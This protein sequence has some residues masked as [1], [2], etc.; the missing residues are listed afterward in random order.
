MAAAECRYK[1]VDRQLKEQFIHGL[2]DNEMLSEVIRELTKGREDVTISS[3]TVLGGKRVEAQR[4]QTVVIS[5]LWESR[6]CDAIA[7]KDNKHRDKN[8][9]ATQTLPEEYAS[10]N[11][12]DAQNMVTCV[13]DVARSIIL[14]WYAEGPRPVQSTPLRK[15][16]FKSKNL[17]SKWS[18]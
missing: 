13:T 7:H 9:Q 8:M 4:V 3:K 15:K 16:A 11:Q 5:S 17:A 12:G 6:N 18:I 1:E 10:I 14:K 2:N